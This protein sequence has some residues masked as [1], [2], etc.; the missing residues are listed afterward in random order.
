MA[1]F[2]NTID[3]LGDDVVI[4]SIIDRSITEFKDNLLNKIGKY[5]FYCCT[6]LVNIDMPVLTSIEENSLEKC[7]ALT[8]LIL[9]NTETVCSLNATSA[10]SNTPIANRTGY[11]YVPSTLIGSYQSAT[12]W[13]TYADK[14]R[15]LEDYTVDGTTTGELDMTKI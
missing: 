9:R 3:A 8:K 13:S 15:V 6:K 2:I 10:L 1:D 4:D 5:A 11:I 12:N 7:S 14:F